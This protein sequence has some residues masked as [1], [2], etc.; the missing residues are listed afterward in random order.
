MTP[1]V[2]TPEV[3]HHDLVSFADRGRMPDSQCFGSQAYGHHTG[4]TSSEDSAREESI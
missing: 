1:P 2:T 4:L 3:R